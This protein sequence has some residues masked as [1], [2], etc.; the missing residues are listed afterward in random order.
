MRSVV[1][2]TPVCLR[3]KDLFLA[4]MPSVWIHLIRTALSQ[5]IHIAQEMDPFQS[6]TRERGRKKNKQNKKV[7]SR[8]HH[9]IGLPVWFCL[10]LFKIIAPVFEFRKKKN[11]YLEFYRPLHGELS[12]CF[13]L[14]IH[15][16]CVSPPPIA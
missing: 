7:D 2:R 1:R 10:F 5:H 15:P 14:F 8:S 4:D 16:H 12:I 13:I 6:A 9:S 3:R 11:I